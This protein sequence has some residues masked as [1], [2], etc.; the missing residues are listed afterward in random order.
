MMNLRAWGVVLLA[1][2]TAAWAASPIDRSSSSATGTNPSTT[3]I[4]G[5]TVISPGRYTATVM[6]AVN[7]QMAARLEKSLDQLPGLSHAK[8]NVDNSSIHFTVKEGA[9]LTTADIER[10]VAKTY[11]G[12]ALSI[13]ILEGSNTPH[14]GL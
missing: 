2:S 11:A 4:L 13:P 14:P 10:T 12:A 3:T 7:S 9:R 6:P 8:V 1:A 5:S